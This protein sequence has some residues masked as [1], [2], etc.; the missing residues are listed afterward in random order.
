MGVELLLSSASP[1]PLQLEGRC[2][3]FGVTGLGSVL[4]LLFWLCDLGQVTSVFLLWGRDKWHPKELEMEGCMYVRLIILIT[5]CD[6][7]YSALPNLWLIEALG[8]SIYHPC[9]FPFSLSSSVHTSYTLGSSSCWDTVRSHIHLGGA[10]RILWR[11][12]I[13]GKQGVRP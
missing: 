13:G 4:G 5:W 1:Q 2:P 9:D 12:W 7:I 3:G 8:S 6:F 11:G 10:G